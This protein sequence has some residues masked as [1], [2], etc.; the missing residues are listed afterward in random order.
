MPHRILKVSEHGML[1]AYEA[2]L[3]ARGVRFVGP[4]EGMLACGYEGCGRLAPVEAI[5]EAAQEILGGK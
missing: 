4:D 1:D 2:T 5:V 3:K